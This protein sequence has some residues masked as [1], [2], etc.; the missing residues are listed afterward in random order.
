VSD[1]PSQ[2]LQAKFTEV[3]KWLWQ[4]LRMARWHTDHAHAL[5]H[6]ARSRRRFDFKKNTLLR[7]V[8]TYVSSQIPRE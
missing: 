3:D 7:G 6:H 4:S 8:R 5:C 2:I 1:L